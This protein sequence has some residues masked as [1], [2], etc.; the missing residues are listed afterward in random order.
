MPLPQTSDW[1]IAA[2]MAPANPQRSPLRRGLLAVR[3]SRAI[4]ALLPSLLLTG[5]GSL[6]ASGIG[7]LFLPAVSPPSL[8]SWME[9]WLISWPIAFPLAYLL[10]RPLLRLALRRPAL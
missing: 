1:P 10:G 9:T 7:C 5:I 2:R 6:V 4:A 3:R 8:S